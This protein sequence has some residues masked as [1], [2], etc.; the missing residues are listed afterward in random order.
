MREC[1]KIQIKY[2]FKRGYAFLTPT[3]AISVLFSYILSAPF[4][5]EPFL[6]FIGVVL[7]LFIVEIHSTGF[8]LRMFSCNGNYLQIKIASIFIATLFSS[9]FGVYVVAGLLNLLGIYEISIAQ[10]S[11]VIFFI[12][13]MFSLMVVGSLLITAFFPTIML[14]FFSIAEMS[15]ILSGGRK[16]FFLF[17]TGNSLLSNGLVSILLFATS[18]II[19]LWK[20]RF[21]PK[22]RYG[23][24]GDMSACIKHSTRNFALAT[25]AAISSTR[26]YFIT[27]PAVSMPLIYYLYGGLRGIDS[28]F[29]LSSVL[30]IFIIMGISNR[31]IDMVKLVGLEMLLIPV[32]LAVV[33]GTAVYMYIFHVFDIS[34]IASV[35]SATLS[36]GVAS[37]SFR[38]KKYCT[39]SVIFSIF[40]IGLVG[41]SYV[42]PYAILL[43]AV[44][45]YLFIRRCG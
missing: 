33:S 29:I 21:Q 2:D 40:G 28:V 45:M 3:I 20:V 26:H 25:A 24:A 41:A 10:I 16:Y 12:T 9:A 1:I 30:V 17:V 32:T 35:L 19:S 4:I 5:V 6:A 23:F 39:K 13:S 27:L 34:L 14:G 37:L 7:T 42:S 31:N 8:I 11:K 36:S 38:M 18:F 22:Y 43:S 44:Y 15:F